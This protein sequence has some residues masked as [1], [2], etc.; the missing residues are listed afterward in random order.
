MEKMT[1]TSALLD[2]IRRTEDLDEAIGI[3]KQINA[4]KTALDAVG[5]FHREAIRYARLEVEA[6]LKVMELGGATRLRGYQRKAAEWLYSLGDAER[7]RYI[8]MCGTGCTIDWVWQRE[9]GRPE[10]VSSCIKEVREW[11]AW[12]VEE[13]KEKG[14]VDFR[15]YAKDVRDKLSPLHCQDIADDLIDG[16]R[17]RLRKAGAVGVGPED[18]LYV[19]PQ[20]DGSNVEEIKKAIFTRFES[21]DNDMYSLIRIARAAK[22]TIPYEDFNE[23]DL[24]QSV[25]D[26]HEYMV[27]IFLALARSGV[28][29][30]S[31]KLYEDSGKSDVYAEIKA[32][33]D[34][35]GWGK[36]K[37]VKHIFEE[38][39]GVK[40]DVSIEEEPNNE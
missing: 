7:E 5:T 34:H 15:E 36:K 6:L 3:I 18:G 24:Y 31:D 33:Y 20:K 22:I 38:T 9:V 30:D 37:A 28:V 13:V 23:Y 14:I 11:G 10:K 19:M 16:T 39:F 4:L 21:I 8:S 35:L 40:T 12:L 29:A 17:N 27:H 25:R 26:G 1:E 2:R 32:V